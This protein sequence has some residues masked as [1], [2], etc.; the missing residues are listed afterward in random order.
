MSLALQLLF[1]TLIVGALYAL[2]ASGF[3][4]I[5]SVTKILHLAHGATVVLVAYI[6]FSLGVTHHLN[7]VLAGGLAILAGTVIGA[8]AYPLVYLPLKRR[9]A[10]WVAYLVSTLALLTIGLNVIQLWYGP[11]VHGISTF[12]GSR[13]WEVAGAQISTLQ[14]IIIGTAIVLLATVSLFLKR[15][16]LGVAMRAVADNE[17]VAEIIGINAARESLITFALGSFLAGVAAVFISLELNLEPQMGT[18][19]AVKIFTA[20]V[21]GGISSVPGA[22]IGSFLIALAEQLAV[23]YVGAGF[24]DAIAF[25]LLFIFLLIRPQGIFGIRKR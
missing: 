16:R 24:R 25:L 23:W 19:F 10:K 1:N 20:A 13:V 3:S 21:I 6:F 5:Y 17:T 2:L 12:A 7:L 18:H 11:G 15:S 22:L 14:L 4:L 9:Q 8:A